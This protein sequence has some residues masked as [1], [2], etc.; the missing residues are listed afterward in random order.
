M[1]ACACCELT[2]PSLLAV[3]VCALTLQSHGDMCGSKCTSG[4]VK[5]MADGFSKV[6]AVPMIQEDHNEFVAETEKTYGERAR[7]AQTSGPLD[8][9]MIALNIHVYFG[10]I[11]S[12]HVFSKNGCM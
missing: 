4:R 2:L 6:H 1:I 7:C 12:Y 5:G 9:C 11:N 8:G 10:S 3:H